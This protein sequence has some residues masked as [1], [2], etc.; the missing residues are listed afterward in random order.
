MEFLENDQPRW[1][2]KRGESDE[3]F[4]RRVDRDTHYYVQK[5]QLEDKFQVVLLL[6]SIILCVWLQ[7][8]VKDQE[9]PSHV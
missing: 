6:F 7:S 5:V 3:H 4:V 2:Q 8:I 9:F 1:K